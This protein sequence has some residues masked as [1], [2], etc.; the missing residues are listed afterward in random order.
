M[1]DR[2]LLFESPGV[3][4]AVVLQVPSNLICA[5]SP[6]LGRHQVAQQ[7]LREGLDNCL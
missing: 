2:I 4:A 5:A 3:P 7:S 6:F 1:A